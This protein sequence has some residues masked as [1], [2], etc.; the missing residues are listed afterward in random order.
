[1]WHTSTCV[2]ILSWGMLHLGTPV[3][4]TQAYLYTLSSSMGYVVFRHTSVLCHGI[5]AKWRHT[6]TLCHEVSCTWAHLHVTV[7]SFK[8]HR[9]YRTQTHLNTLSWDM[10]NR[11]TLIHCVTLGH[12][13]IPCHGVCCTQAHLYALLWPL[14]ML[15][16]CIIPSWGMHHTC[17]LYHCRVMCML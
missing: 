3:M 13:C 17:I 9:I 6:Y 10:L 12:I 14:G 15:H 8:F 16:T 2:Y 11:G 5:Y 7:Y 1:M 4:G